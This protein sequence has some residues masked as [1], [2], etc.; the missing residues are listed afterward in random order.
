[1]TGDQDGPNGVRVVRGV[2][3]ALLIAVVMLWALLMLV[4]LTRMP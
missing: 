1:M 3:I 2:L 4:L